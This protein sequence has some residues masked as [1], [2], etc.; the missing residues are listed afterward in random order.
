ML[1]R[2]LATHIARTHGAR[3]HADPHAP[4]TETRNRKRVETGRAQQREESR[5]RRQKVCCRFW[6][7]RWIDTHVESHRWT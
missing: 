4:A 7:R 1:Q 5:Q 6:E 3:Q 2:G